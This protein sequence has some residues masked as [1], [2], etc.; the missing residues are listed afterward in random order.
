MDEGKTATAIEA[1]GWA[2]LYEQGQSD[3][4]VYQIQC[5]LTYEQEP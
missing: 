1:T 4:G 2:Y 5:R 3:T